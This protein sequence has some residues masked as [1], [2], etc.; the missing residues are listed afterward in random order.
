MACAFA[1]WNLAGESKWFYLKILH[2]GETFTSSM[3]SAEQPSW[4]S[5]EGGEAAFVVTRTTKH[6]VDAGVASGDTKAAPK[7]LRSSM[8]GSTANGGSSSGD[9]G[10]A[11]ANAA[12]R[13][14]NLGTGSSAFGGTI[15]LGDSSGAVKSNNRFLSFVVELYVFQ[16]T[17]SG[18][19]EDE[20]IGRKQLLVPENNSTNIAQS[21]YIPLAETADLGISWAIVDAGAVTT[22]LVRQSSSGSSDQKGNFFPA[23]GNARFLAERLNLQANQSDQDDAAARTTIGETKADGVDGS[24]IPGQ[25]LLSTT[26]AASAVEH[27]RVDTSRA[28]RPDT[29][30]ARQ[31]E[32]LQH[33]Q[34][35]RAVP[36]APATKIANPVVTLERVLDFTEVLGQLNLR[37]ESLIPQED[38]AAVSQSQEPLD[39]HNSSHDMSLAAIKSCDWQIERLSRAMLAMTFYLKRKAQLRDELNCELE[40]LKLREQQLQREIFQSQ[41]AIHESHAEEASC[42]ETMRLGMRHIKR[43][44]S[45]NL[46]SRL[47]CA[48]FLDRLEQHNQ[49]TDAT[50]IEA[51]SS[52]SPANAKIPRAPMTL[53]NAMR[54]FM[55]CVSVADECREA[56]FRRSTKL[57]N[58]KDQRLQNEAQEYQRKTVQEEHRVHLALHSQHLYHTLL[59]S[60]SAVGG[61]G[62]S[63]PGSHRLYTQLAEKALLAEAIDSIRT[64]TSYPDS[65]QR[66]HRRPRGQQSPGLG[67]EGR[68]SGRAMSSEQVQYRKQHAALFN[69]T[70]APATSAGTFPGNDGRS[71]NSQQIGGRPAGPDRSRTQQRGSRLGHSGPSVS[72]RTGGFEGRGRHGPPTTAQDPRRPPPPSRR[73]PSA[74][75]LT[76][77]REG[78]PQRMPGLGPDSVSKTIAARR[79]VGRRASRQHSGGEHPEDGGAAFTAPFRGSREVFVERELSD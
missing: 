23:S 55:M 32:A 69:R 36:Q 63:G 49:R 74:P 75:T 19:E 15:V 16:R 53:V 73:A 51:E 8:G 30:E 45:L 46:Q 37:F 33:V 58:L 66:T 4:S 38:V 57:F 43:F 67:A 11:G 48:S 62:P 10:G 79:R 22:S 13:D 25:Q 1:Y 39:F 76:R 7:A 77:A 31:E 44:P 5:R 56:W 12:R 27:P 2:E 72:S 24:S 41:A 34:R 60:S 9:S 18:M 29:A 28:E 3:V 35:G 50:T 54:G 6:I 47:I 40:Q 61:D 14:R 17:T 26:N 21:Q 64:H 71:Q 65:P 52:V 70:S 59:N 20:L 68:A 42:L 78:R